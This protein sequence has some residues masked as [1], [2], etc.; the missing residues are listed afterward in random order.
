MPPS[1]R[2]PRYAARECARMR[3]PDYGAAASKRVETRGEGPGIV[4]THRPEIG[5]AGA[6]ADLALAAPDASAFRGA[7]LDLLDRAVGFDSACIMMG[8]ATPE[9]CC[10]AYDPGQVRDRI[11]ACVA[12]LEPWELTIAMQRRPMV[13]IDVLP[14]ARRDRLALYR[15]LLRP[16]RVSVMTTAVWRNA[17]GVFGFHLGRTGRGKR[18]RAREIDVLER[19]LPAIRLG[20]AYHSAVV[21]TGTDACFLSFSDEAGLSPRERTIAQL[22]ARGLQNGEIAEMLGISRMTV[23]NHLASVYAKARVSTRAELA[24]LGAGG[25]TAAADGLGI[26]AV[27][28]KGFDERAGE[29]PR[30]RSNRR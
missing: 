26:F 1:V 5:D 16:A 19:A 22:V 18:F 12:E 3:H 2:A 10:R 23:K 27:V 20:T 29:T 24:F 30:D 21:G 6:I 15:E 28:P 13:D 9:V 7:L 8:G 14:Q 25:A 11:V 17:H 4:R